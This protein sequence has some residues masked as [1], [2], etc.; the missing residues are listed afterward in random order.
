[1]LDCGSGRSQRLSDLGGRGA[2]SEAPRGPEGRAAVLRSRCPRIDERL[3]PSIE[4]LEVADISAH[5]LRH[6]VYFE[7]SNRRV[8]DDERVEV[9]VNDGRQH[10]R[11][12]EDSTYDL[13]TLE[14][15]PITAAGVAGL[16]SRE[17]F[18][19]ANEKLRPGGFVSQLLPV[20]QVDEETN[21]SIVKAF[22]DSFDDVIMVS[23]Y[24]HHL[25]LIGRKGL[26]IKLDAQDFMRR[27]AERPA[28]DADMQQVDLASV[29]SFFGTFV[30][31]K[32][33][34]TDATR[35]VAAMSD[36]LPRTEYAPTLRHFTG[37]RVP[38]D[39]FRVDQIN[40]WFP[41]GLPARNPIARELS[42]QLRLL[43]TWYAR[44]DFL[45]GRQGS[46]SPEIVRQL[47]DPDGAIRRLHARS[48]YLQ[49]VF[50]PP[51][52]R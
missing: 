50:G 18:Q 12:Q 27:V 22:V 3:H 21:R 1:M 15:P 40:Q 28:V 17:F 35:D 33:V 46:Q 5:V 38:A 2:A 23:A 36:D 14:P 30:A 44:E 42:A 49:D 37:T 45:S 52:T 8:L 47:P 34:L 24:R 6:A 48:P 51:L 10:L 43:G 39:M 20:Y 7:K 29:A 41:S 13:I 26:P 32:E 31:S 16:Y 19:L 11:M 4:R 25:I 9:Y